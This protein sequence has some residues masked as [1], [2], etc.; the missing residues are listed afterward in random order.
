[1]IA[2][3]WDDATLPA[4][5]LEDLAGKHS[6]LIIILTSFLNQKLKKYHLHTKAPLTR[7]RCGVT[8]S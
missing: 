4:A 5:T 3:E 1:M 8:V 6:L 7:A 2:P